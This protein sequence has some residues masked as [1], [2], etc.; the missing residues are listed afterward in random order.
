MSIYGDLSQPQREHLWTL[1]Y[2]NALSIDTAVCCRPRPQL[3][4]ALRDKG[5][6]EAKREHPWV[7]P[8]ECWLTPEGLAV[9][10]SLDFRHVGGSRKAVVRGR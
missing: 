8:W 10:R 6:A 4:Q 9:M 7:G 3:V 5:L 2:A 1:L